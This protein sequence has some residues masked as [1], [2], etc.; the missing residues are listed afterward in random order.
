MRDGGMPDKI[1]NTSMFRGKKNKKES[2]YNEFATELDLFSLYVSFPDWIYDFREKILFKIGK[3]FRV[4]CQNLK[5][6]GV[7]FYIKYPIE[8]DGQWK[9]ADIY[10]P[11]SDLVVL[12]IR[13]Y[14]LIGL[15][16]FS[17]TNREIWFGRSHKT[18]GVC[19]NDVGSLLDKI[20]PML[21]L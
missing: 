4:L 2:F 17:K 7:K 12:L 19:D 18:I 1:L 9:F 13:D 14:E 8:T 21:V 11:D 3:K 6:A 15:P 20:S 16:C 5:D 10:I